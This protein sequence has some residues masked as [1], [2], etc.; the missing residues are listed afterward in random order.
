MICAVISALL[1]LVLAEDQC[2][3]FLQEDHLYI[4]P[5]TPAINCFVQFEHPVYMTIFD[6]NIGTESYVMFLNQQYNAANPPSESQ[7]FLPSRTVVTIFSPD[8]FTNTD[9]LYGLL[10]FVH[11][12][13]DHRVPQP[14][15]NDQSVFL[16]SNACTKSTPFD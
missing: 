2:S 13:I 12:G 8:S 4:K 10:F 1:I 14:L 5:W 9:G 11:G 16:L 15:F 6:F 7:F 3:P